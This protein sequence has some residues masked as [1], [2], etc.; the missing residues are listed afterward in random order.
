MS[1]SLGWSISQWKDFTTSNP[2]DKVLNTLQ[3]LVASFSKQDPAWISI[4]SPELIASQWSALVKLG[5][6]AKKVSNPNYFPGVIFFLFL[7]S[8]TSDK[9]V[10]CS[11]FIRLLAL[12]LFFFF[13]F[14]LSLNNSLSFLPT[15][16]LILI[17]PAPT[18][19]R[20]LRCE[21]QHRC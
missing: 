1:Q 6:D 10:D 12:I 19:R 20:P 21:R 4:A 8:Y 7:L 11:K 13:C 3:D 14:L 2:Q 15:K 16:T 18:I 9:F 5:P 17:F